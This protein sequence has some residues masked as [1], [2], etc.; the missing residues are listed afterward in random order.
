[1]SLW[2]VRKE[3]FIIMEAGGTDGAGA[4]AGEKIIYDGDGA[5]VAS[6][7]E[8]FMKFQDESEEAAPKWL[9]SGSEGN[10]DYSRGNCIATESGWAMAA[11]TASQGNDN[12]DA[13]PEVLVCF[14]GLRKNGVGDPTGNMVTIGNLTSKTKFYPDGETYTGV[15]SSTLGD[16]VVYAYFNEPVAVI[17][18]VNIVLKQATALGADFET[19]TFRRSVS[20]LD[21]GIVAFELAASVDTQTSAV[22]NNTLG[23]GSGDLWSENTGRVMKYSDKILN[24]TRDEELVL[25]DG[26]STEGPSGFG[27]IMLEDGDR[28]EFGLQ[29]SEN[30]SF[31]VS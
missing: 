14:K 13:D 20:N 1:M 30:A 16:L 23:I 2:G 29:L 22:T 26:A 12:P 21:A 18:D 5:G 10:S 19:L 8:H 28:A 9:S 15:A 3:G 11:G 7:A 4:N 27:D 25:D 6:G 17:G 31:A 24:E